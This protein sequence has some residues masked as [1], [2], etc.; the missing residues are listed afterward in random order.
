MWKTTGIAALQI[1]CM[2]CWYVFK[3]IE[4]I[5]GKKPSTFEN[6]RKTGSLSQLGINLPIGPENPHGQFVGPSTCANECSWHMV[7][8]TFLL[9]VE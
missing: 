3:S 5:G 1:S 8:A 4:F 6:I 9:S 2:Y 7:I